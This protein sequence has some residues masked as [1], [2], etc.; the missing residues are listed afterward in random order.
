MTGSTVADFFLAL[1]L[2]LGAAHVFGGLARRVGQPAVV[3]EICAGLLASPMV[4]T[5]ANAEA[6]LPVEVK[7]L[8]GALANVGLA[9][10]MFLIG[11]EL[12]G[13]FLRDRRGA[14]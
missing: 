11:Y 2:V 5:T 1:S 8:L 12:D 4:I 10:F 13:G 9:T 7:P 3:G 14:A 6:V